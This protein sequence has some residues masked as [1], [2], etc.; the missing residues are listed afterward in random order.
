MLLPVLDRTSNLSNWARKW[1]LTDVAPVRALLALL[2]L[3]LL[4]GCGGGGGTT[5]IRIL[6][7]GCPLGTGP[8]TV[9]YKVT[10]GSA[11]ATASIFIEVLDADGIPV[12]TAAINR[13]GLAVSTQTIPMVTPGVYEI[14]SSLY[15]LDNAQGVLIG[16]SSQVIDLCGKTANVNTSA[17]FSPTSMKVS[18]KT[19]TLL[20]QQSRRFIATALAP[21]GDSAF[22]PDGSITW[23]VL[24]GVG[25]VT[26]NGNFTATTAG[27]GSVR[28]QLDSPSIS[29]AGIANV[30]PFVVTQ[31]K[32]TVLVFMNAAN[33]L[34]FASDLNVNQMEQVAGNPDVRFVIQWKQ[35]RDLFSGSS[36]DGVRRVLVKPDNSS[37]VVSEVVQSNLVDGLGNPLDMGDPDTL[38]D[39]LDWAKTFY[40]A[41]RY[42]LV[43]W[44]HG[45]GWMRGLEP[46]GRAF[47]FD[48][49]TGNAIEVYDADV[50]LAG[51]TFDIIAW[52]ASLMQ[53]M[54]VA[55][56]L[57]DYT[58][59]VVG[60][61]ESP[62]AEGYPYHLVFDNFRDNPDLPTGDL[63]EAFVDAMLSFPPYASKKITQSSIDTTKLNDLRD[64]ISTLGATLRTE[65][66]AD[67]P[68]M[69]PR[70]QNVRD[71]FVTQSYS[72]GPN[73][74]FKDLVHLCQNL[75]AEPG[76]P[77]SIVNA[78]AATRAQVALAVIW[79]GHNGNSPN[80]NGVAIDFSPAS[81]FGGTSAKYFPLQFALD[82]LWDEWLSDAP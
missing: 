63:T 53:M 9:Q 49:Q 74:H 32:W 78:A 54:E 82:S 64:A 34:W 25:T 57:R 35:S 16:A 20:E 48:D 17:A 80:S 76:M 68:G 13:Q 44:N 12:R 21:T 8:G 60:S 22:V 37:T 77:A 27:S 66:L 10:W 73:R 33:D 28:A 36:F 6:G 72:P 19:I 18:P 71:P 1:R 24:G 52:D 39:F 2:S 29:A 15:S 31:T 65:Y 14:R 43:L 70:I 26:A 45:S 50:A 51:H 55:Y 4:V 40:P 42:C 38:K 67:P 7:D 79:E 5:T 56:E 30:D 47:S 58:D 69:S 41:D 46:P 59:F 75:E 61:E 11:P 23:S 81:S 62:P 3:A